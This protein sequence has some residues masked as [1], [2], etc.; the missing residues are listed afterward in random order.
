MTQN[1]SHDE[2][3]DLALAALLAEASQDAPIPSSA[4]LARIATD[5]QT[6][7]A[8]FAQA[9]PQ[10]KQTP[11]WRL[12][13]GEIGGLPVLGGLAM[14]ACVGAYFGFVNP[15]LAL[16]VQAF[17][18]LDTSIEADDPYSTPMLGDL[19]WIDEG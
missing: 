14:S 6:T 2:D 5:A 11:T 9:R 19:D 15:Q 7:Q 12:W 3:L 13:L 4:L 10:P 1:T 18:G 8:G 17:A 16:S